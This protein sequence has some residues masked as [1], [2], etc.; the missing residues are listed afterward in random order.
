MIMMNAGKKPPDHLCYNAKEKPAYAN[1]DQ[2][3]QAKD[4][5]AAL[6]FQC[7]ACTG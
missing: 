7:T 6:R 4:L 2:Q 1:Q 3:N 5:P